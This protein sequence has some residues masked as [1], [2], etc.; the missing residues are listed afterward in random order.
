MSIQTKSR[1]LNVD[2]QESD[3]YAISRILRRE[4]FEV[5]EAATGAETLQLAMEIPD[6]IILDVR[7]PDFNGFE[8]CRKLKHEPPTIAIP[9]LL[10]T[11]TYHDDESRVKGLESGAEGYLTQPI[12]P[13]VLVAH[14]N[15]L[16]RARNALRESETRYRMLLDNLPAGVYVV[17]NERI[18]FVNKRFAEMMGATQDELVGKSFLDAAHPEDRELLRESTAR[19]LAGMALTR[20]IE[21][22]LIAKDRN[23]RW[24]EAFDTLID[25]EGKPAVLR[26]MVDVAGR[27]QRG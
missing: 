7:L 18:Q 24:V 27:R 4:G 26:N 12:E 5:K 22:R 14:I 25:Y 9:V 17:Q 2:D 23:V 1:I 16:L 3:R 15:A 21:F 20:R 10:L 13:A 6:L 19:Q 8:I 11:A